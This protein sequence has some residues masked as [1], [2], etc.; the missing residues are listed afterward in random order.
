MLRKMKVAVGLL[1]R[2]TILVSSHSFV[3]AQQ[4]DL[5]QPAQMVCPT[6]LDS[7]AKPWKGF[8]IQFLLLSSYRIVIKD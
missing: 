2:V 4:L 7:L 3:S 1:T 8:D 6:D 5:T